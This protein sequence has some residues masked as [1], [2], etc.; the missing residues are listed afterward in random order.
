MPPEDE[1]NILSPLPPPRHK[2]AERIRVGPFLLSSSMIAWGASLLVHGAVALAAVIFIR[3]YLRSAPPQVRFAFGGGAEGTLVAT[4]D[5][6]GTAAMPDAGPDAQQSAMPMATPQTLAQAEDRIDAEA[7]RALETAAFA[8]APSPGPDPSRQQIPSDW[9]AASSG[10]AVGPSPRIT[11]AG[12]SRQSTNAFA[13]IGAAP[14][15]S[16]SRAA[17]GSPGSGVPG[18]PVGLLDRSLPKPRYPDLSL[19][20]GEQGTVRLSVD[21]NADGTIGQIRVIEDPGY[22]RLVEAAIAAVRQAH[23]SPELRDGQPVPA[24]VVIPFPFTLR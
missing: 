23:F 11:R 2:R 15:A 9:A 18:V 16:H 6:P 19:R 21:V 20:N 1:L 10:D 24:V 4:A 3:N 5:L 7:S 13:Q 8:P 22:P 14:A 12:K 17:S